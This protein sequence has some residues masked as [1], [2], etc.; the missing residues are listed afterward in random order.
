MTKAIFHLIVISP[1]DNA[2]KSLKA[3]HKTGRGV[4]VHV[5]GG[6]VIVGVSVDP[7]DISH[8]FI[9]ELQLLGCPWLAD[10]IHGYTL[11]AAIPSPMLSWHQ[12]H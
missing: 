12:K 11:I 3:P 4:T 5:A 9:D 6:T 1:N 7:A 10:A 8:P 2:E